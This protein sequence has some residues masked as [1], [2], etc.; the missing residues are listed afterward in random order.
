MTAPARVRRIAADRRA[1]DPRGPQAPGPA[2]VRGG[3]ASGPRARAGRVRSA[4]AGRARAR[5]APRARARR[6]SSAA[7]AC[8]SHG[9]MRLVALRGANTVTENSAAGDPRRDGRADAR[10]PGAQLARRRGSRELHLHA[11]AGPRRRVPGGRGARDGAVERAAAVRA[12]DPGAG[13]AAEGHPRAD[14]RLHGPPRRARLPRRGGQAP[15][16]DLAGARVSARDRG[17]RVRREAPSHP[18]LSGR[19]RLRV[20][21]PGRQARLQRVAVPADPGRDRGGDEGAARASTATPTPR[22]PRC[23][24]S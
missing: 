12:R 4:A 18:R 2:H 7:L 21:G 10:D 20:R 13:R 1:D 15:A 19:R 16:L 8:Q 24:A 11:H 22:T 14:P 5:R 23:A 17:H 6:R 3:R 9:S